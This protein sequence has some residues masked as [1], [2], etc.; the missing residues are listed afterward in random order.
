MS[1]LEFERFISA[2]CRDDKTSFIIRNRFSHASSLDEFVAVATSFGFAVTKLDFM[3]AAH[4][5]IFVRESG[6]DMDLFE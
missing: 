4:D 6:M 3:T 1:A 2:M 5:Q